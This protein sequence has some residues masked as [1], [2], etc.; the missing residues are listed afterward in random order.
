MEI[1]EFV[2]PQDRIDHIAHIAQHG[3]RLKEVGGACFSQAL[4]Q[5]AQSRGEN[6]Y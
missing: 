1:H 4:I 5:R 2:W 6:I 3:V